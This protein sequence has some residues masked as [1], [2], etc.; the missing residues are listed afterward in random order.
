MRVRECESAGV[1]KESQLNWAGF[2]GGFV[3]SRPHSGP[4]PRTD[5]D[6]RLAHFGITIVGEVVSATVHPRCGGRTPRRVSRPSTARTSIRVWR[7]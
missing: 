5:R 6:G 1:P 7:R 2:S 4:R 3:R